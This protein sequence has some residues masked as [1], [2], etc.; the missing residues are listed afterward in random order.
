LRILGEG[1][2]KLTEDDSE[3]HGSSIHNERFATRQI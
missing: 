1:C 3:T 2:N